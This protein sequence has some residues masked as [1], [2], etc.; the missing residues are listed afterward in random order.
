MALNTGT[1]TIADLAENAFSSTTVE[2]FGLDNLNDAIQ[3]DLTIHNQRVDEMMREMAEIS[4]ERSSIY[5][6][7]AQG[8]MVKKDEFTRAPTQRIRVG[9]KV[10]FPLDG[11]EFAVGW[12]AD[13]LRRATVQDM[14]KATINA[15]QAH[16]RQIQFEVKSALFVPTNYTS[17]DRRVDSMALAV[18]RLVNADSA[19]VPNGPNGETYNSA[20][21]THYDAIDWAAAN[22]AARDAAVRALV[23]DVVEHGHGA[24][25]RIYINRAQ[26]ADYRALD[27]FEPLPNPNMVFRQTDTAVGTLDV[28]RVD[29]RQIGFYDGIPVWTKPWVP[30]LYTL[31]FSSGDA[32]KTLRF[33]VS[34]LPSERGLFLA[35]EII[36][37]PLQARYMNA[38]FG[39]GVLTRTNG[40]ILYMGG[41]TYTAPTLTV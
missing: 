18:K 32:N 39:V 35:G 9:D 22:T 7:N 26:E 20:T 31:V 30:A 38:V 8:E 10:E 5:G 16:I 41:G 36:T 3:N 28:T 17:T 40:A 6:T 34:K 29:N 4:T 21:H 1:H 24:E 37:H 2:E 23:T 15:R 14:A 13:F 19:P 25:L 33:R 27:G 11:Y 12:T